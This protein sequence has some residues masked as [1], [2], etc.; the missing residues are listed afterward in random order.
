MLTINGY[1]DLST[2]AHWNRKNASTKATNVATILVKNLE[3]LV[4]IFP[5]PMLIWALQRSQCFKIRVAQHWV[6]RGHITVRTNLWGVN[7]NNFLENSRQAVSVS[8]IF[9]EDCGVS[10]D[11]GPLLLHH[12]SY[13]QYHIARSL[14]TRG[15]EGVLPVMA[16]TCRLSPKGILF[17]GLRYTK[18]WGFH[19]LMYKR[20]M[21]SVIWVCEGAQKGQWMYFMAL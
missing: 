11:R 20:V 4:C 1:Q 8:R 9:D 5:S 3:T 18:G 16:Y 7:L 19:S 10:I 17:S 15:G 6:G 12:N 13:C 14:Q 21:K 2:H